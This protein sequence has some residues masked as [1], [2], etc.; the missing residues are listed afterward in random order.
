MSVLLLITLVLLFVLV[1]E[2]RTVLVAIGVE[3]IHSV[4]Q[5][6]VLV[7]VPDVDEMFGH[8]IVIHLESLVFTSE[9]GCIGELY[10]VADCRVM[11]A[12]IGVSHAEQTM[13][14]EHDID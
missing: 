12:R 10:E 8:L 4:H 3:E 2:P 7:I 1:F 14:D 9:V 13:V 5:I 11:V 6:C